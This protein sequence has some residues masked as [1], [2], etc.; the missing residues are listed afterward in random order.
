MGDFYPKLANC[1]LANFARRV[2]YAFVQKTQYGYQGFLG[3][4]TAFRTFRRV[5]KTICSC[6]TPPWTVTGT[7]T[8]VMDPT[9]GDWTQSWSYDGS[10]GSTC[11]C[12]PGM[13]WWHRVALEDDYFL[14][15]CRDA[16]GVTWYSEEGFLE[17][18][19]PDE[20]ADWGVAVLAAWDFS[21][22]SWW[23][24]YDLSSGTGVLSPWRDLLLGWGSYGGGNCPMASG[25]DGNGQFKNVGWVPWASCVIRLP[26][27]GQYAG[28][29]QYSD[30]FHDCMV[31]R[32][33]F[34]A[35][36]LID[37]KAP[38]ICVSEVNGPAGPSD[39]ATGVCTLGGME[40]SL[41]VSSLAG[42]G[43][44]MVRARDSK[45]NRTGPPMPACCNQPQ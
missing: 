12:G 9:T 16:G 19:I 31:I 21:T 37:T 10:P 25:G 34:R 15:E 24:T 30:A 23:T 44:L 11:L 1:C 13:L 43:I 22:Q 26:G 39:W 42:A 29:F 40:M 7:G 18:E 14:F 28:D 32:S 20:G 17:D 2:K 36:A 5:R 38:N 6:A 35:R 41:P 27:D 45:A 4:N 33:W 3:G 8:F